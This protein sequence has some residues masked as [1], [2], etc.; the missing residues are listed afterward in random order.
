MCLAGPTATPQTT[1]MESVDV[2][3]RLADTLA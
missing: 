2:V 1:G 3:S